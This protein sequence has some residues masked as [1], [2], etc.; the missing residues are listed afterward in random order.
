MLRSV[1]YKSTPVRPLVNSPFAVS[2]RQM[3]RFSTTSDPEEIVEDSEPERVRLRNQSRTTI[4]STYTA[5]SLDTDLL[6]SANRQQQQSFSDGSPQ[7]ETVGLCITA[8]TF[9]IT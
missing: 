4:R 5:T 9:G 8:I 6:A 1:V 7:T 2:Q 3:K